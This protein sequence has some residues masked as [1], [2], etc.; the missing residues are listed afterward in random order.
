LAY[1]GVPTVL[2][3]TAEVAIGMDGGRI[4]VTIRETGLG[5]PGG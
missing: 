1:H 3:G 2:P 4:N 5:G